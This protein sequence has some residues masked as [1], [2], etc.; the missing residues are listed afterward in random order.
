MF[1]LAVLFLLSIKAANPTS[2]AAPADTI[3]QGIVTDHSRAA[4]LGADVDVTCNA[5][6]ARAKTG[7]DGRYLLPIKHSTCTVS[8]AA[9]GFAPYSQVIDG[10]GSNLIVLDVSLNL[11]SETTVVNVSARQD[12]VDVSKINA[13]PMDLPL[14]VATVPGHLIA[15]QGTIRL[16][17]ALRNVSGVTLKEAYFGVTDDFNVRGFDASTSLFN[18][19]RRDYYGTVNDISSLERIEVIKGPSSVTE[20]FLEPGG[21]VNVVTKQPLPGMLAAAD[22]LTD[23]FG[24]VRTQGDVNLP[25]GHTLFLRGTGALEHR[26]SFRDYVHDNLNSAGLALNWTPTSSTLLESRFYNTYLSGVPD[27]GL[28]AYAIDPSI[29]FKLPLQRFTG[30]PQ[31][32]YK[33]RNTD[34]SEVVHQGLGGAWSLRAGVNFFQLSDYRN[35]VEDDNQDATFPNLVDRELTIVPGEESILNGVIETSGEA[36]TFHVHHHI[37]GGVDYQRLYNYNYF[38][39]NFDLPLFNPEQPNYGGFP[40]VAG[41]VTYW[42]YGYTYDT[43]SYAQDLMTI[44]K[45]FRVLAGARQDQFNYHDHELVAGNSVRLRQGAFSPRVGLVFQP[46]RVLSLYANYASSFNPQQGV[47]LVNGADPTPSRGRQVELGVKYAPNQKFTATADLFRIRKTNVATPV[48]N[49]GDFEQLTGKEQNTGAELDA[50]YRVNDNLTVRGNIADMRAI[51]TADDTL[52][53]GSRLN[54]V[55]RLQGTVW[56]EGNLPHTHLSAGFG[57]FAV[58]QQQATLPN[59]LIV[60]NYNRLDAALYYTLPHGFK[61]QANVQNLSNI[62][63]DT[64]QNDALFPGAPVHAVLSLHWTRQHER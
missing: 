9:S 10:T 1:R 3:L 26:A 57:W 42:F 35:N 61:L 60:P 33:Q 22:L 11:P 20:G 2:A 45:Y 41:P 17:D 50:T 14:A 6:T 37:S 49:D 7:P 34:L 31:D 27:R 47:E 52:P 16:V 40:R 44:G 15:D 58:G 38:T 36:T 62:R 64:L 59:T 48:L 54:N 55:P 53:I 19:F 63:Y 18:G 13:D 51:V 43:G 46:V 28:P 8:I 21:I 56:A 32:Q 23:T 39:E 12:A 24:T 30:D 4:I 5:Y 25:L 29:I